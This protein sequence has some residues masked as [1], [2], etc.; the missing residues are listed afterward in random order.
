MPHLR[1]PSRWLYC[2]SFVLLITIAHASESSLYSYQEG[3]QTRWASPENPRGEKGRGAQSNGGRKGS[4]WITLKNGASVTLAEEQGVSGTVRRIWVTF[5]NRTPAALRGIRLEMFWDGAAAPA[6]SAP[7]GDFFGAGLGRMATFEAALFSSPEGRSFNCFVPMPFR[8]GMK[9]VAINE[10]G[11]DEPFFFYDVDYTI[12]DRHG[13][14]MLYFHAHWR[15]ENP[16]K[17]QRDFEILPH[18]QGKG[19]F[20]GVNM[21]VIVTTRTFSRTWWGE[22]EV[23]MYL[24]GDSEFPTLAGTGTEDYIGTGW[25]QGIYS[26]LYQGCPIADQERFRY[27]FYRHHVPDPVFFAREARVTIQQM[28]HVRANALKHTK[29]IIYKA[30]PGLVEYDRATKARIERQDDVS[31]C[32]Y[33][34]LDRPENGLPP[35]APAAERIK[36]LE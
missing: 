4:A 18:V 36:G 20:L 31:S 28:G 8:K 1:L 16:T 12:G 29:G 21:G 3:L 5:Y 6:V 11:Q 23:K 22:G 14:D 15:R 32:A 10:S 33:F 7:I 9:I 25:S 2:L 27:C 34:Y 30:G 13:A 17:L 24:D 35:L 19:R 26:S